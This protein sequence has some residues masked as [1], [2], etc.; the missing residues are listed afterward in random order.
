MKNHQKQFLNPY[1]LTGLNNITGKCL[2]QIIRNTFL[3]LNII[4][5]YSSPRIIKIIGSYDHKTK[6][7]CLLWSASEVHVE[8]S[9]TAIEYF[10][11]DNEG[12]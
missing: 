10:R 11:F 6:F 3:Y 7:S 1:Y 12:A 2:Q 9:E 5:I 4:A 8:R